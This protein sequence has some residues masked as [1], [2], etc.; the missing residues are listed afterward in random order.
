MILIIHGTN[1]KSSQ[2]KPISDFV[3][4][5][6]RELYEGKIELVDLSDISLQSYESESMYK[7]DTISDEINTIQSKL[8]VPSAKMIFVSPEYNGSIPGIL[9]LFI[10][11]C[12][13]KDSKASFY[14][15]KACL[16]GVASGR[17]GNLRGLDH[18]AGILMYMNMIIYPNK[19]PISRIETLIDDQGVV[20]DRA[21]QTVLTNL[22]KEFL[23]F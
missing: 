3:C 2:S 20:I 17:A 8:L 16:I 6:L 14:H 13:I 22:L 5:A 11:A 7:A 9:K 23:L 15:K 10:D 12:S 19:L 18:L 21:T 1:R 4:K